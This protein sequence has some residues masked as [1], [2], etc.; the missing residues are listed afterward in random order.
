M[1]FLEGLLDRM[2]RAVL[3]GERLDR[4]HLVARGLDR[5]G[6][7]GAP[8]LAVDQHGA[9]AADAVLA[10]DMGAGEAKLVAEEIGE[11]HADADLALDRFP[12]DGERDARL[13]VG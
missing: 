6:E 13:R 5:E 11:Q 4:P 9:G 2:Q 1:A 7:A 12:I 3:A 10:A 8:G